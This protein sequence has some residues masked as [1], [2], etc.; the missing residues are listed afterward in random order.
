MHTLIATISEL[1]QFV[2]I[3]WFGFREISIPIPLALTEP[4][5]ELLVDSTVNEQIEESRLSNEGSISHFV[6][7]QKAP[8]YEQPVQLFDGVIN[9]LAYGTPV[10]VLVTS[11]RWSRVKFNGLSG[12]ILKDDLVDS[13]DK[14]RP[15]FLIGERY[16]PEAEETKQLRTLIDD[17]FGGNRMEQSLQD[18]EY[19]YYR[20][21]EQGKKLTWPNERPRVA[22]RWQRLLAGSPGV[23]IGINPSVGSL[24]EAV[25]E[26]G[27][28]YL[29]YVEAVFPDQ[30]LVVS[31]VGFPKEGQYSERTMPYR[32]WRELRPVFIEVL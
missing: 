17:E 3:E 2:F 29:S 30:S 31:G 1:F 21:H 8:V 22:G 25:L 13:E 6:A 11:G 16:L 26:D 5:P 4:R 15:R 23:H 10:D 12:W 27:T 24:M 32:E 7:V 14:V 18:V 19:V 28:G 9:T 20:L